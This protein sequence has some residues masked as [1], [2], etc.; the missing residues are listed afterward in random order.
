MVFPKPVPVTSRVTSKLALAPQIRNEG[1]EMDKQIM[2]SSMNLQGLKV[3]H[4]WSGQPTST[5]H[6]TPFQHTQT[7]VFD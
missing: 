1:P 3:D 6:M 2:F 5:P 4:S 7:T